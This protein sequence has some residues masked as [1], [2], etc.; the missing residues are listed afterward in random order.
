MLGGL[1]HITALAGAAQAN[2]DFYTGFLGLRLVKRTVN[3]DDPAT[4]HFY[5]SSS[6]GAPGTLAT[7]FP[8]GRFR[9]SRRGSGQITA[10]AFAV[11]EDSLE[12]WKRRAEEA[13]MAIPTADTRFGENVLT[14]LDPDGIAIE[15][16][17]SSNPQAL[18]SITLCESAHEPTAELLSFLGFSSVAQHENRARFAFPGSPGF[19]DLL[20]EPSAERGKMGAGMIH[21][22][23]FRVADEAAQRD[24]RARLLARGLQVSAVK[25]RLYFHSIYFRE[26]GGILFAIAPDGPGFR[27]DEAESDLGRSLRLPPWLEPIRETVEQR[28]SR[29]HPPQPAIPET[30]NPCPSNPSF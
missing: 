28:L 6:A 16:V 19:V 17:G 8:W 1:H 3:F 13:S 29:I 7:F 11:P 22:V 26:P 24:W 12:T 30:R 2:L 15:L 4:H 14:I 21:H 25:D 23:A 20:H 18:H 10:L 5:F 27:I 9:P